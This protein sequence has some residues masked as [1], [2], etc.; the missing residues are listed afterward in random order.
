MELLQFVENNALV[1]GLITTL[2]II[3]IFSYFMWYK[4]VGWKKARF[5]REWVDDCA[6]TPYFEMGEDGRTFTLHNYRDFT[7]RTTKD[8]DQHWGSFSASIDELVDIWFVLDHFH[9]FQGMAHT[10]LT[11]EFTDNRYMT[12]SFEARRE[13]GERYHPWTGLWRAFELYLAW[14]SERDLIGLRTNGR[15]NDVYLYP[16]VVE[17]HKREGML[18]RMISRTN[19]LAEK[20]EFYNTLTKTCST[21]I[22]REINTVTPGRLPLSW[23]A[24]LPGYVDHL[25]LRR[26]MLVDKGGLEKTKAAAAITEKAREAG[27]GTLGT[28]EYSLAIRQ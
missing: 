17:P 7:W 8:K 20:P 4:N 19:E 24:L 1:V 26:G 14:G 23:R 22:I 6:Q 28:S 16:T 21:A 2:V 11:F 15:G 27:L 10:M 9:S 13:V 12:A 3:L 18:L 5:D 25:A